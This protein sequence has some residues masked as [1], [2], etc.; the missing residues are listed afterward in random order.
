MTVNGD[1]RLER[2]YYHCAH[3]RH[4]HVPWDETLGLQADH[5]SPGLR[6]LV[7]L[8]G[9]LSPFGKSADVLR[10]LLGTRLSNATCRRVTEHAGDDLRQQHARAEPVRPATVAAWDF[11]LP[12]RDDTTFAS[13]VAYLG[14][15]AFAVPTRPAPR[16]PVEWRM[17]YVGLLYD[18]RKQHTVYVTD[19]DFEVVGGLL[20]QYAGVFG[21]GQAEQ[22]VAI[23]DGGNGLER[24]LRQSFSDGVAFVL[25]FYHVA[26]KLHALAG[27]WHARDPSAARAWAEQAKELLR[28][29]GGVGLLE[30]LEGLAE[31]TGAGEEL[32][33][34]R[35]RL[36][37]HL[38]ENVHRLE[39]G[40]YRERGW[41]I[42]SGPTEAG[43]KV[44]AGRVK[45]VG[46]RWCVSGSEQVAALRA[47]YTSG[48]GLWDAFWDSRARRAA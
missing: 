36:Q 43:C 16:G 1:V 18:P 28:T 23:T 12:Q 8:V 29:R 15:D 48:E 32:R 11:T 33:A 5:L 27:L 26:E 6:P 39:Y 31:P 24:V 7:A 38:R 42:G 2:A 34:S 25:D 45:G 20:R 17:L 14:L 10:R 21:L 19:F 37:E 3:C 4:G 41:D 35:R 46:M 40:R 13:S 9:T 47:L 30:Y 22:L 44:I